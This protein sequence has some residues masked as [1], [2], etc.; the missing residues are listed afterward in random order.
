MLQYKKDVCANCLSYL[1]IINVKYK[2]CQGCNQLRL[3]P[4]GKKGQKPIKKVSDKQS[5]VN[6][7]LKETYIEMDRITKRVCVG[8]GKKHGEVRLSHSHIISRA[9]AHAIGRP[10]LI[11]LSENI[12]YLCLSMG[13]NHIGC[14]SCWESKQRNTLLCY[15][16]NMEFIKSISELMFNKYL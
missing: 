13:D 6:K 15:K 4:E 14:H 8:C 10:D 11:Y 1:F 9:D 2:L 12:Q 16:S 7:L 3:H 5:N